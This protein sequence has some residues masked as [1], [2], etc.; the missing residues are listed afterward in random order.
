MDDKE[1]LNWTASLLSGR[2]GQYKILRMI[3]QGTSARVYLAEHI[4]LGRLTAVKILTCD[5]SCWPDF[6]LELFERTAVAAA[7]L[8]HPNV[9]TLFDLDEV[10]AR[11]F[12][13]MEY[14][15]GESLQALLKR[16]GALPPAR[17]LRILRDVALALGH[18]HAGGLVHCDVKPANILLQRNGP[19]KVT[20]FGLSQALNRAEH[21]G[22][23]GMIVGTPTYLS[24]EQA[25]AMRPDARS[26]L[27]SLGVTFFEMLTG[28]PPWEGMD[29][30]AIMER[31]VDVDRSF[32]GRDLPGPART[33][34]PVL[35][36]LLARSE[37]E[38]FQNTRE[39]LDDL[40]P[41]F[42]RIVPRTARKAVDL[43][44]KLARLGEL[45]DRSKQRS[46]LDSAPRTKLP[47]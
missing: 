47:S 5:F 18:A 19:A 37:D 42:R 7:R 23:D 27:Y 9:V 24:P 33:L 39:L 8:N 14:V 31:H 44:N 26:D 2:L 41:H 30:H 20:D 6:D 36:R 28:R 32:I 17:A 38:R 4:F 45:R 43:R 10:N 34:E 46:F 15:D 16:T 40:V 21:S 11:P 29:A 35:Q 25:L 3:G 12:L 13:L 1:S 22:L